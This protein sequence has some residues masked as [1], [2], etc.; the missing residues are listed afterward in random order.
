MEKKRVIYLDMLRIV[1][2]VGVV[3]IHVTSIKSLEDTINSTY[4][5]STVYNSLVRWSVPIFFMIS[6]AMFLRKEKEYTFTTM[7]KKY[8][9]RMLLCLIFWGGVYSILDIYVFG[10]FSIKSIILIPW[11]IV[12]NGT[13]YHLWYLYALIAIYLMIPVYKII[14]NNLNQKQIEFVLLVWMVFSLAVSQF[15]AITS[16]LSIGLTL[17]WYCPLILNW[18]GYII[19]GHYLYTYDLKKKANTI[20][21][22]F[23]FLTLVISAVGNIVITK[24]TNANFEYLSMPEGISTCITATAIFLLFKSIFN[25]DYSEN[26]RKCVSNISS[27]TFGIYLV[28]VLINTLVFRIIKFPLNFINPIVSIPVYVVG[29]FVVSYIIVFI[30]RKIPFIKK[31]V[32]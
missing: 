20:L 30:L 13:G 12:A 6:G 9:P 28:H 16:A 7:L 27:N 8:I 22:A 18:G 10:S 15:N 19:L 2:M 25:K 31:V 11:Q 17:D 23:G 14:V 26:M 29:I 3:L 4:L 32:S 1:S 5:V 24:F 21:I